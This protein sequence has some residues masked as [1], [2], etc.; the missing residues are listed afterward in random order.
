MPDSP[1]F[2]CEDVADRRRRRLHFAADRRFAWQVED[3]L[4]K[5]AC[6]AV[7][8][9]GACAT[10]TSQKSAARRASISGGRARMRENIAYFRMYIDVRTRE[11]TRPTIGAKASSGMDSKPGS[12]ELW[13]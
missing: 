4:Q 8:P 5:A 12:N 9:P 7:E 1:D 10:F 3:G 13:S 6:A 2:G 11:N